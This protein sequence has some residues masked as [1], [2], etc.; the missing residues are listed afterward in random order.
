MSVT[1]EK[2]QTL[3][4]S[5]S[6]SASHSYPSVRNLGT[7]KDLLH[8]ILT[9]KTQDALSRDNWI[10]F[11]KSN[12]SLENTLF[13]L[14]VMKFAEVYHLVS[15]KIG[16]IYNISEE[17]VMTPPSDAMMSFICNA[18]SEAELKAWCQAMCLKL[19]N[20]YIK[21]ES[22]SE[23]NVSSKMRLD[24]LVQ[25]KNG[26]FSPTMFKDV[27]EAIEKLVMD[28]DLSKFKL[29]SAIVSNSDTP[30][31]TLNRRSRALSFIQFKSFQEG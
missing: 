28:N 11:V 27:K 9:N 5:G 13:L 30:T 24:C 19:I 18:D 15:C 26:V 25:Y 23:I 14:N 29:N 22:P 3:K 1:P 6:R 31:Q 16:L 7:D 10:K 20:T 2:I 21:V 17:V 12:Y 8:R 4:R